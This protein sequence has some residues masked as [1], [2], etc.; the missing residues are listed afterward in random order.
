MKELTPKKANNVRAWLT[1]ARFSFMAGLRNPS[2]VFFGFLF[3]LIFISIFGLLGQNQGTYDL[4]TRP[5]STNTGAVYE[6]L[7]KIESINLIT[8][9]TNT[10]IDDQLKKGQIPAALTITEEKQT[11]PLGEY[12]TYD[13]ELE[14]SVAANQNA[15]V[16]KSIVDA[17]TKE[18]NSA[19]NTNQVTIVNLEET[20]VEGRKFTQIDFILPGQ[21]A[22]M[23]LTTGV[24]AVVF[25]LITLR[26][27]LVIKRMFATPASKW[28]IILGEVTAKLLMAMLQTTVIIQ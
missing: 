15:Q 7:T 3:P 4:V 10:E 14:L 23:L 2:S 22:F 24:Y 19:A 17:V 8:D 12:S 1:L 5:D 9:S 6:A 13:L 18:I 27:T 25:T 21:L 11:T 28:I 20:M 26:S 16:V